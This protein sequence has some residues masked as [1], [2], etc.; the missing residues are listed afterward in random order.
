MSRSPGLWEGGHQPLCRGVWVHENPRL[1]LTPGLYLS[2]RA[3]NEV[4]SNHPPP[5]PGLSLG[6]HRPVARRDH[7][8]R[9]A[10]LNHILRFQSFYSFRE[11]VYNPQVKRSG[12]ELDLVPHKFGPFVP[13]GVDPAHEIE[14]I[15]VF[16]CAEVR[17]LLSS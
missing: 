9:V 10:F 13:S 2:R 12:F 3:W 16:E 1:W 6:T 11:V 8:S 7:V 14:V 15:D 4:P 17:A 5:W